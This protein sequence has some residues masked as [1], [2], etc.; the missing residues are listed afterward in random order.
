MKQLLFYVNFSKVLLS[1]LPVIIAVNFFMNLSGLS[2]YATTSSYDL[3]YDH[4][5][6]DAVIADPSDRYINQSQKGPAFHTNEFMDGYYDGFYGCSTGTNNPDSDYPDNF[7]DE[8]LPSSNDIGRDAALGAECKMGLLNDGHLSQG[9]S[10][11]QCLYF[12]SCLNLGGSVL[13]CYDIARNTNCDIE[14]GKRYY[15]PGVV[16]GSE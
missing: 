3:G 11:H 15:C 8:N 10:D 4:G 1:V 6:D 16:M 5:C 14:N 2:G 7:L 13:G 12:N 9:L